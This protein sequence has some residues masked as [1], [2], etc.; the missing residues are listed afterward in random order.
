MLACVGWNPATKSIKKPMAISWKELKD[1][2]IPDGAKWE[3]VTPEMVKQ[4]EARLA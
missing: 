4:L 2:I 1:G 3:D